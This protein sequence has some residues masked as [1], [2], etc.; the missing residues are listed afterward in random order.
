[1]GTTFTVSPGQSSSGL[2]AAAGR[3][4]QTQAD[5]TPAAAGKMP[6]ARRATW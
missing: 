4:W 1:M 2:G 3:Y 6:P 5:Q